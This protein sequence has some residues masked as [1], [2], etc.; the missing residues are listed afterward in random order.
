M[1]GRVSV[2]NYSRWSFMSPTVALAILK[3]DTQLRPQVDWKYP[4]V[5]GLWARPLEIWE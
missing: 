1:L 5:C 4:A 3:E 2:L